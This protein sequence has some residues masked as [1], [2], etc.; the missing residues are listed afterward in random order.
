MEVKLEI[1]PA[2]EQLVR[3]LGGDLK[4]SARAGLVH[5]LSE[6]EAVAVKHTPVDTSNLVNSITSYT[7]DGGM[8]GILKATAPYAKYVHD[9]TGIHGPYKKEIVITPKKAN[10]LY[11]PGAMHPVKRVVSKGM[12]GKPFF[13]IAIKEVDPQKTFEDGVRKFLR[14]KGRM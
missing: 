2:I 7:T 6:L 9:G 4:E 1:K 12:K 13:A 8:V 5:L 10:A 3:G 14:S 11:W